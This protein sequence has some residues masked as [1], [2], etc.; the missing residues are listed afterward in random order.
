MDSHPIERQRGI[1][2]QSA[3]TSVHWNDHT[4][5]VIDT[6]GHVDFTIEV[7]RSLRVL[8]GAV[9]VLCSVGGVQSQSLTVDRQMRRYRVPRIAFINKMDRT[10]A[11]PIRV[12]EQMRD[13]LQ[14]N[15]VPI[16]YPIGFESKFVG[17][18]DLIT[19]Q[20]HYYEGVSGEIVRHQPVPNELALQVARA[21]QTMLESIAMLDDTLMEQLLSG[22]EPSVDAIRQ[23]VRKGTIAHQ[24]T[25]VL[26]GSAYKNQG[27]QDVLDAI[28]WYLPCPTERQ[29]F[30]MAHRDQSRSTDPSEPVALTGKPNDP[31]VAIA[32][33]TVVERFGQLTLVRIYQGTATKG[34]VYRNGRTGKS[35]RFG[36]LVKLHADERE[37]VASATVGDIVGVAGID[38]ASGDTLSDPNVKL[39]L[40][41]IVIAEPVMRL[42]IAPV[43][44][45]DAGKLAKALDRFRR[46]DPTFQVATD[47]ESGEITIAGMGQLHLEVYVQRIADDY[48]CPCIVDHPRVA[49]KE[50]PTRA[51]DFDYRLKKQTG[52]PGMFAQIV[53][54]MEPLP[55]DSEATF[56]FED[57]T[58]GG[59][60]PK[61]FVQAVKNGFA[62]A[63]TLGPLGKFDVVGTKVTLLSGVQHEKDSSDFAF[64]LCALEAMRDVILPRA[65]VVLLEPIMK[66]EIES[67]SE[68]QGTIAG[69]LARK[70]GNVVSSEVSGSMCTLVVEAPLAELFDYANELRSMTQGKG[71]FRI[72][73]LAYRKRP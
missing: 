54:R 73:P 1:T 62:E 8:D 44:R 50:R 70:R 45:D 65:E 3:V 56:V 42:A 31:L 19:M 71:T 59:C 61:P 46:E 47:P 23:V 29:V 27:V 49:Y 72:E 36:R 26:L 52:G 7:E 33:K 32:F 5:N 60:I 67:P 17:V 68:Y 55:E 30:A 64:R 58:V 21:R 13:R 11:D 41:S 53:G 18:V 37:E 51:V 69:N 2:I 34:G 43:R 24:L 12:I 4:I 10:G 57:K 66:I 48:D 9:L 28:A 14:T 35:V 16:Q 63:L 15:A 22:V 38:C 39:T 40:E 25:P 20:A 6:P